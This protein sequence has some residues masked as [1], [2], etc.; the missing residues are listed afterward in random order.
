MLTHSREKS[1]DSKCAMYCTA[2]VALTKGGGALC[3]LNGGPLLYTP[4]YHNLSPHAIK[5]DDAFHK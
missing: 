2:V 1:L 5:R 4:L 3:K